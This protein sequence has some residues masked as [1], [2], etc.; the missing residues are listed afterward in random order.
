MDIKCM[1]KPDYFTK[2]EVNLTKHTLILVVN[3]T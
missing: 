1:K 2:Y 3:E